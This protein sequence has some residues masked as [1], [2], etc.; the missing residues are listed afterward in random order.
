MAKGFVDIQN[1]GWMGIDFTEPGL[2]LDQVRKITLDLRARGTVA[3]CPTLITGNPEVYQKNFAVIAK[4]MKDPEIGPH[5]LGIHLEGPFISPEF[6]AV[7]AHPKEYVLAPDIATFD[8]F[9]EWAEGNIRILT[10]APER[11]GCDALISHV[12]KRGVTVS[13]GHHLATDADLTRA[14]E[15]GA[16]LCTHVGNGIPNQIHRHENPLWWQLADDR[17]TGMFITDGHHLPA[18][19]IKVALRSKTPNR[20]IVTSDASPL[21]GMPPGKYTI[22]GTL[23]VAISETGLIYSEKSQSLAG[24]HAVMMECMNHLASLGYLSETELWQVGFEN[25]IRLLGLKA[26][27][28]AA[29]PGPS[30]HYRNQRFELSSK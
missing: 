15:A 25:Q 4:A 23:P 11:P 10:V 18:D 29:L 12:T 2:T 16:R 20:F 17:V 9:Q 1:N 28:F 3:Y 30:V 27:K 13:I 14:V 6:G 5:I 8:R 26:E 21:A 19:L 22:F 7:G 24:S